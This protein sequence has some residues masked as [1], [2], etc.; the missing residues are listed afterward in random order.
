MVVLE[1]TGVVN[2]LPTTSGAVENGEA[3]QAMSPVPVALSI[4]ESGSQI[5]VPAALTAG[6]VTLIYADFVRL[7]FPKELVAVS[8]TS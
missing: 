4:T 5:K 6:R 1:S 8:V 3:Y 2:V 7:L